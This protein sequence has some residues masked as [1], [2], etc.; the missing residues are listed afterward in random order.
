MG[1][2]LTATNREFK[3]SKIPGR[4]IFQQR[5]QYKIWDLRTGTK[6]RKNLK[7]GD[8]VIFYIGK[9]ESSFVG[10]A[11]LASANFKLDQEQQKKYSLGGEYDKAEYGI[12]LR[13]INIWKTPKKAHE[14]IHS[15]SFVVKKKNW[16]LYIKGGIRALTDKDF[17]TIVSF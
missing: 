3:G 1:W 15:L 4:S 10:T 2:I 6:N 17:E 14:I 5:M 16:G 13:D 8:K 11:E 9:P 12:K 7:E